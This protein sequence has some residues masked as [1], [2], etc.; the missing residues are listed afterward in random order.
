MIVIS[1]MQP[2]ALNC[3]NC[4][5]AVSADTPR[6]EFCHSRLKTVGCASCLGTMFLGNKFCG[7][8]GAAANS[9][10][11]AGEVEG[12]S[13]PRCNV[14]LKVLR[15]G[16]VAV[17]ECERCGGLW[18]SPEVFEAVCSNKE[19]RAA[20]LGSVQNSA[21]TRSELAPIKYVPCPDCGKLMNRSNFARASG[22]I[23]DMCKQHGVWFDAGELPRIIEFIGGGGMDRAREKEKIAIQDERSRLRDEERRIAMMQ[24]R[25][26]G[27]RMDGENIDSRLGGILGK[28]FDL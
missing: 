28:L 17:R 15:I 8:C 3:P 20:V 11:L 23:I 22:V 14:G 27:S 16:E 18:S 24:R 7:H 9:A 1:S 10:D 6:C 26:G 25:S 13:C 2:E 5:A 12:G 21:S 19:S 4:G